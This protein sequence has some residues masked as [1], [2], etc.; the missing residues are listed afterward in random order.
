M[1][2][3][4]FTLTVEIPIYL[5]VPLPPTA[6]HRAIAEVERLFEPGGVDFLWQVSPGASSSPLATVVVLERPANSVIAGCS[7][8]LHDHRLGLTDLGARRVTLWT[9][10]I[11]R[12]ASGRW[13]ERS[14]PGV[15]AKVLGIALGRVL[16]HELGHLFLSLNGHR[17]KGLMKATFSHRALV[18]TS[19][20]SFRLSPEDLER[21]R[22]VLTRPKPL[23][24]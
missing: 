21:V 8:G 4:L 15:S 13:D 18:G 5:A 14:P 24:D 17:E 1:L 3:T 2:S 7:R 12:A 20:R 16:A 10:Q 11:V 22:D 19:D 6:Y 23:S 9:E